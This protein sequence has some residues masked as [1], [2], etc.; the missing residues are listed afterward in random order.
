MDTDAAQVS[1]MLR[2]P[3]VVSYL[4]IASAWELGWQ[5]GEGLLV[6]PLLHCEGLNLYHFEDSWEVSTMN[7]QNGRQ[8][9]PKLFLRCG[10][11]ISDAAAARATA[12]TLTCACLLIGTN[13][14]TRGR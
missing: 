6:H 3:G 12:R 2:T 8:L 9:R 7:T 5:I 14:K 10:I 1:A 11:L 4:W 13:T